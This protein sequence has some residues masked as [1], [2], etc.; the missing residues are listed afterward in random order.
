[1]HVGSRRDD[2]VYSDEQLRCGR[3]PALPR[4][5][6]HWTEDVGCHL[7]SVVCHL[8]S[9]VCHLYSVVCHLYYVVC[10]LYSVVRHLYYVVCH[11]YYVICHLYYVVRHLYSVG[12]SEL[13]IILT[14]WFIVLC[15]LQSS[16]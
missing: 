11:L 8:Y 14:E 15:S 7:Y 13:C 3:R 12:T 5:L 6:D 4:E 1:M 10:H 16:H 9:V 2:L